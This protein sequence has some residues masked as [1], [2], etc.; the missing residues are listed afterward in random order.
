MKSGYLLNLNL[1]RVLSLNKFYRKLLFAFAGYSPV[2]F[3]FFS[4]IYRS[5][6]SEGNCSVVYNSRSIAILKL[7][8]PAIKESE[9]IP[10]INEL[11]K[12]LI[13]VKNNKL[14]FLKHYHSKSE[15]S[16]TNKVIRIEVIHST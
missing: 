9:I 16:S 12:I 6:I 13:E 1:N 7:E 3:T 2:P 14:L 11:I 15:I 4:L 5:I 8:I 10:K